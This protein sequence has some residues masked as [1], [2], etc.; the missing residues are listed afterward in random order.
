MNIFAPFVSFYES[1]LITG[2]RLLLLIK[3]WYYLADSAGILPGTFT[4]IA[5]PMLLLLYLSNGF[6]AATYT[7]LQGR[8]RLWHF[9][10]ALF[11]PVLYPAMA[12]KFKNL[13]ADQ[14]Q[15][16]KEREAALR[17]G[18]THLVTAK[19]FENTGKEYVPSPDISTVQPEEEKKEEVPQY[20]TADGVATMNSIYFKSIA[21]NADGSQ[22]GPFIVVMQDGREME[23]LRIAEVLEDVVVFELAGPEGKIRTIR[24]RY[25]K[26]ATCQLRA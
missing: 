8:N 21:L 2:Q 11:L 6:I 7:E 15:V 22:A 14:M 16:K 5:V 25:E 13:L 26:I 17:V 9:V 18:M 1:W 3:Q 24:A 10:A 12:S 23:A 19:L 4:L 20:F